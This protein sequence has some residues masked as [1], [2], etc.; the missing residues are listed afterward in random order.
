MILFRNIF[1][2][3]IS[4]LL[5]SLCVY[6]SFAWS[7]ETHVIRGTD[8]HEIVTSRIDI[9]GTD[10]V[11]KS[12]VYSPYQK[13]S[14][15]TGVLSLDLGRLSTALLTDTPEM[16]L[17]ASGSRD[18]LAHRVQG[19]ISWYDP[20]STYKLH[21]QDNLYE[22]SQ[23]TNG[24]FYIS[25]ESDGTIS[26]YSIDI[27]AELSFFSAGEKMTSIIL[28][29]G[30]YIRFDP[31]TSAELRGADLFRIM[32]V[33]ADDAKHTG[34]EF[35]NPR[36]T[37]GSTDAFFMYRL[38]PETRVIF[39]MLRL[40]FRDRIKQVEDLKWYAANSINN[41]PEDMPSIY[42]PSKRNYYVLDELK[43]TLSLA[44]QSQMDSETF[45]SKIDAINTQSKSLVRWN[46]VQMLLEGFLT[47][48][49]FATFGSVT[50]NWFDEIYAETASILG[51]TPDT[52][53]GR[54][55]QYLSD[56]YSRNV[57]STK[58]TTSS[59]LTDTY[60]PT[61]DALERTL[62]NTEIDPQDYFDV[63]LYAYQIIQKAQSSQ[64]TQEA[65]TSIEISQVF[66]DEAI[67]SYST[68]SLIDTLFAATDKYIH[69]LKT[70]ELQKAAYQT[71]VVQF[72]APVSNMLTR[73]LYLMYTFEK[74]GHLYP[75]ERYLDNENIKIDPKLLATI[76]E[77]YH[78]L[79]RMQ[80]S[81]APLYTSDSVSSSFQSF[82]DSVVQLGWWVAMT[83]EGKYR[84]YRDHPYISTRINHIDLPRVGSSG[85]IDLIEPVVEPILSG[86]TLSGSSI[87]V[88]P[89]IPISV[90]GEGDI[91]VTLPKL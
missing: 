13:G 49:R 76:D 72:Y 89:I 27:V 6:A 35:A 14:T 17:V 65:G 85:L 54:L 73:S 81:V 57:L 48:A 40:Y 88:D 10:G 61:A 36:V 50:N 68:Y 60:T 67:T 70:L 63:S 62:S 51:I 34:I 18:F 7:Q 30:M 83:R 82:S 19:I 39:E 59:S 87:V 86:S 15:H 58:K 5:A 20:F 52:S 78:I 75:K 55:F 41:A 21:D 77:T 4:A 42:N 38:P 71:L 2:T 32:V 3:L 44:V 24:S 79:K 74:D 45:R 46:S 28:F 29:P 37:S 56:I 91:S 8:T 43:R 69:S 66:A 1:I 26:I 47:D 64:K 90:S 80:E 16:R 9:T 12:L 22:M 11:G 53:K 23:I 25:P 33:L 31:T 84:E